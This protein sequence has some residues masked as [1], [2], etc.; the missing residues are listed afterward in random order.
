MKTSEDSV[1]HYTVILFCL[2]SLLAA[3]YFLAHFD[4]GAFNTPIGLLIAGMKAALVILFFMNL[5]RSTKVHWVAATLGVFWLG[6]LITLTL[7]DYLSRAWLLL[8]GQWP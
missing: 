6:I 5:K 7:S 3:S 4:L 2:L 8:P 1:W